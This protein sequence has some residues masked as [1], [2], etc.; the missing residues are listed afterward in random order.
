MSNLTE[1]IN[2]CVFVLHPTNFSL[3]KLVIIPES[4]EK[5]N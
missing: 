2:D 3:T 1:Y 5:I 4:N